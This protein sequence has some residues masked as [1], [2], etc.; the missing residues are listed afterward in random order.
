[1]IL[2]QAVPPVYPA[3]KLTGAQL[4]KSFDDVP[5]RQLEEALP[6]ALLT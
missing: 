5:H 6:P 1:M 4:P 2:N 3:P